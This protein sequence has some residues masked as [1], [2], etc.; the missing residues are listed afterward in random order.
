M[1]FFNNTNNNHNKIID[2]GIRKFCI[3]ERINEEYMRSLY[4]NYIEGEI[5]EIKRKKTFNKALLY[6]FIILLLLVFQKLISKFG[7]I[8]AD[9]IPCENYDPYKAFAWVSI[10]H[11]TEMVATLVVIMILSKTLKVNFGLGFGD[12]KKGIKF[13]MVFTTIF[14]GVTLIC[15]I[16]MLIYNLLPVYNYPLYKNNIMGTLGFQLLLSGPAEEILFRALPITML[17][18]IWKKSIKVKWNI[19]LEIIIAAL[20]FSIAHMKWSL[21]PFIIEANFFQLLYAFVL[22]IINGIAYQKS[23]SII[24]PMIIH[25]ISNVLMVGIGYLFILL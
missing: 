6:I 22:G 13:V 7:G 1:N 23:K 17:V 24:Y 14:T 21:F 4:N 2:D 20:L 12:K 10:H 9:A 3:C 15:H 8:V 16:L 25:S 18:Y 19:T 5:M 11:I